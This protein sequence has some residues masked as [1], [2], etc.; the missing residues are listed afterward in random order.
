MHSQI[1]HHDIHYPKAS[2]FIQSVVELSLICDPIH[3]NIILAPGT[4]TNEHTSMH[5]GILPIVSIYHTVNPKIFKMKSGSGFNF[6]IL[7]GS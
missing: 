7:G 1:Y 2:G 3:V 4:L 6:N 5:I